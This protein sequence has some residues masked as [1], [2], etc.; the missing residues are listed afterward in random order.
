M[1]SN[2]K[3]ILLIWTNATQHRKLLI[4][5]LINLFVVGNYY[6]KTSRNAFLHHVDASVATSASFSVTVDNVMHI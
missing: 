1:C 6:F 3:K 4:T 5:A 2:L